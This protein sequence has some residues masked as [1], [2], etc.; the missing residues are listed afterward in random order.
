MEKASLVSMEN[1]Q[2]DVNDLEKGMN[3][4]KKEFEN[5]YALNKNQ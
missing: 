5:R 1:L 2:I 3:L 4:V